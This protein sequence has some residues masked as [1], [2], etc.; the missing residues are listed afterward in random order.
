M[1]RCRDHS[2]R[3][4]RVET[5][6]GEGGDGEEVVM[7]TMLVVKVMEVVVVIEFVEEERLVEVDGTGELVEDVLT[8]T[9]QPTSKNE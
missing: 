9:A 7:E 5:V 3:H 4:R 6:W 2:Q 8:V 1:L